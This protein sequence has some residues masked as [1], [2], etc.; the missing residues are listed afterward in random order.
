MSANTTR[1]VMGVTLGDPGKGGIT[2]DEVTASGPAEQGGIKAGDVVPLDRRPIHAN[3]YRLSRRI[4]N[5]LP[6]DRV[7][8]V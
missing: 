2:I 3:R 6:G 5:K 1:V 4:A 7:N 8:V